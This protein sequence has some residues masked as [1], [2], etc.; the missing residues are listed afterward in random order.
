MA[1]IR[2]TYPLSDIKLE[3]SVE[4]SVATMRMQWLDFCDSKGVP[5]PESNP[6][7]ITL[8]AAVYEQFLECAERFQKNLSNSGGSVSTSTSSPVVTDGDD[9]YLKFGGAAIC[10]MLHQHYKQIKGCKDT[11]RNKLS[12]EI[13]I[14]QAMIMKDK[15][16]LP[17]YLKYWHRGFMYFPDFSFVPFIKTVHKTVR[18]AVSISSLGENTIEVC[19]TIV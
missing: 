18:S 1:T 11:Q 14:L 16:N 19:D 10:K 4:Q 5:V 17:H 6:V 3:K 7:M 9:I 15:T 2:R 13:T 12:Q 8:S